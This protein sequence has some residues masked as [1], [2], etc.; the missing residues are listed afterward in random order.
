V[1]IQSVKPH[2]DNLTRQR[3]FLNGVLLLSVLVTVCYSNLAQ[4]QNPPNILFILGDNIGQE[5]IRTYGSETYNTPNIDRLAT[6][7][8]KF[9]NMIALPLCVPS[10]L[11]LDS[12]RYLHRA[13]STPTS[14]LLANVIGNAGYNTFFA[15]KRHIE[16]RWP[17]SE[18]GFAEY[19]SLVRNQQPKYWGAR[20][21]DNG[22]IFRLPGTQFGPDRIRER[23]ID[24]LNENR[25][26]RF[27]IAWHLVLNHQP[28]VRVPGAPAEGTSA[29]QHREMMARADSDIGIVLDELSRL[30]L[31]N[32]TV[33]IFLT[34]GGS[35]PRGGLV[36][37]STPQ[38]TIQVRGGFGL[39]TDAGTR[40]P[41]IVRW[42]GVVPAGRTNQTATDIAAIL[43]TLAA[44]AGASRPSG[45]QGENLLPLLHGGS[46][47]RN[48]AYV[49]Y[50]P[51]PV[52][53][54]HEEDASEF[55]RGNRYKLYRTHR[56]NRAFTFFD[57][58]NDPHEEN[59]ISRVAAPAE[60][61]R[62]LNVFNLTKPGGAVLPVSCTPT[63]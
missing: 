41:F 2:C 63:S 21:N 53:P 9:T 46:G 23:V 48:W 44:I 59:P 60:Y 47:G 13:T 52:Q 51:R 31:A 3:A 8:M 24:Y 5:Q 61:D 62:L 25:T 56:C 36:P 29:Q 28:G 19:L 18:A 30:G 34:D 16:G 38:G 22:R 50:D 58:V 27:F 7:G 43:P 49:W 39:P 1:E 33:V 14:S 35:E 26:S 32:N 54:E 57:M 4:A 6:Q 37:F 40:V 10:R 55:V 17:H 12:G 11:V 42:P 45:V 15:G 20:L